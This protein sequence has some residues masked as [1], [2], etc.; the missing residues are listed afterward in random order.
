MVVRMNIQ[1]FPLGPFSTNAYLCWQEG[2]AEA[3]LFDAPEGTQ[4]AVEPVLEERGLKL[5]DVYLTHG[6][7]DHFAGLPGMDQS[8]FRTWLHPEDRIL[9]ENPEV[10]R[11]YVPPEIELLPAKVDRDLDPSNQATLEILGLEVG[12]R[13]VPGHCPGSILFYFESL[14]LAITGDAI[15][16]GSI[17]RTDLPGGEFA[18][19]E[20]SIL[21]QIYT[22]PVDTRLL[23]GHGAVTTVAFEME[24][25]PFVRP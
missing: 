18:V 21:E 15:F 24:H 22:L 5:T 1:V 4:D 16:Q 2:W 17:G 9:V 23:P 25:N 12:L 7:W 8:S 3:V 13:H 20:Q 19:L 14:G 10:A 11:A 6:H